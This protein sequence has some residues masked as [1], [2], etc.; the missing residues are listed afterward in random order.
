MYNNVCFVLT[1]Y[2]PFSIAYRL[3]TK[4]YD[5]TIAN[6]VLFAVCKGSMSRHVWPLVLCT[7]QDV[8]ILCGQTK[9]KKVRQH[10]RALVTYTDFSEHVKNELGVDSETGVMF[11][12]WVP[13]TI[14]KR[15][16]ILSPPF[17]FETDEGFCN[18]KAMRYGGA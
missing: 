6:E 10:K 17:V 8:G 18:Y 3:F 16:G 12:F 7:E 14:S 4:A 5:K 11:T 9:I 13:I 1:Y 2:C 15:D